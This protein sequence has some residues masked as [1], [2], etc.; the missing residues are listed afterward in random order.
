VSDRRG[1]LAQRRD[2][3]GVRQLVALSQRLLL[4]LPAPLLAR[5]HRLVGV[6]ARQ[7][8]RKDVGE[9]L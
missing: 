5:P 7:D 9:Q 1:Q 6:P 8:V 2:A 4:R 3:L